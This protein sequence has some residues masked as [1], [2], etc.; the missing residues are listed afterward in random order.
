MHFALRAESWFQDATGE[1]LL[2][3]AAPFYDTY[4]T[5]DGKYVS[6]GS[7]EPQFYALLLQK[8]GLDP[9]KHGGLGA[10]S[11]LEPAARERWPQLRAALTELFRTRTRDEWCALLEGTDVC[12][13]PVLSLK[14]AAQHPHNVARK[15]FVDV[16]GTV[17]NA[18]AP[19]FSRTPSAMP[20][21]PRSPG[22]DTG[23]VLQELGLSVQD[24]Q[25]LRD[26]GVLK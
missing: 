25:R 17:Q 4:E 18:P 14:E 16:D 21:P 22:E 26:G 2:A 13:A 11:L 15:T 3:G 7:L 19:R 10:A 1:N 5:R 8:L 20:E 24:L 23:S 12:F 9:E 6:I